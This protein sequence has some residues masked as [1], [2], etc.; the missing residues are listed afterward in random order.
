MCRALIAGIAALFSASAALAF[1][2]TESLGGSFRLVDQFGN[3]RTEESPDGHA[4]LLFF[5]YV[6]C[7]D[8]CTAAMPLMADMA[9]ELAARGHSVTPIMITVDPDVDTPENMIAPLA[10]L[11][12]SFVGLTGRKRA[13]SA[14][15]DAYQVEITPL[16][17]DP[18]GQVI[19]AHGSFLYLLDA[20]G[21]LLTLIPPILDH[22]T[23]SNIAQ[24]YLEVEPQTDS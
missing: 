1:D 21:D 18:A 11:H 7:P 12:E 17:T 4:Q 3:V 22:I 24:K 10:E 8:I 14:S 15:Y 5:G 9:D 19:Y 23:A 2:P 6:N 13:L 16:F 20:R